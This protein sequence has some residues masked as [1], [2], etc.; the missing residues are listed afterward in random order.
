MGGLGGRETP[1]AR[2]EGFPF[3]PNT[4]RIMI[5]GRPSQP[6]VDARGLV[7]GGLVPVHPHF[8]LNHQLVDI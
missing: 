7:I 3:P 2:A 6:P 5:A 1:L 8:R 4:L